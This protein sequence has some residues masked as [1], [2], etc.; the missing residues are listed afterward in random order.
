[1]TKYLTEKQAAELT[2]FAVTTFQQWRF[3]RKGPRYLKVSDRNI[4]YR[5]E[6]L[7]EWMES[8]IVDLQRPMAEKGGESE[9]PFY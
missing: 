9:L 5:L 1:M 2:G 4:R 3:H 6:D 7:S 8:C